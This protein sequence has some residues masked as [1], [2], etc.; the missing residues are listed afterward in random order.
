MAKRAMNALAAD[1]E[2]TYQLSA[3]DYT[4]GDS[5]VTGVYDN[6]K[7]VTIKLFVDDV[8]VDEITP[9]NS[10]N[11]YAISTSKTTIVKDSKVEVAEYDA[12]KNELT[13]ILV[14]VIDPNGGGNEMDEKEKIDKFIS[15]KLT[16]LNEKDGIVY[17]QLAI[18][19]IQV[20]QK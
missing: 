3:K 11:I 7:A 16:V 5:E 12:D 14:T 4:I 20:N 17:E 8:A 13:K 6:E 19:V 10:K 9:D 15:R 18:R 1:G 2:T